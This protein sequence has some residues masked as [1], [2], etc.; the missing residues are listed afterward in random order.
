MKKGSYECYLKPDTRLPMMYIDD[1]IDCIVKFVEQPIENVK[2]RVYNVQ[3]CS[4]T[5]GELAD[6][7]KKHMPGL[8]VTYKIDSRQQI[9]LYISY[10]LKRILCFNILK[11]DN[12]PKIMDDSNARRDWNHK[13]KFDLPQLV[14]TMLRETRELYK[15]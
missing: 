5:P 14:E 6:E 15:K 2:Q 9:G 10:N 8:N 13:H 4:F 3:A 12:W 7:I 1:C 11:A